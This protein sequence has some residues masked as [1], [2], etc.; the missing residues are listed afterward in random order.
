MTCSDQF[1]QGFQLTPCH[2]VLQIVRISISS[3]A[4]AGHSSEWQEFL[5]DKVL[6]LEL[7]QCIER[8]GW[9]FFFLL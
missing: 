9:P 4:D 8:F 1:L 3:E 7:V 2:V 6:P 5:G